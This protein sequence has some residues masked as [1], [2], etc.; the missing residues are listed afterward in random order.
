MQA[1]Y[2]KLAMTLMQ[3]LQEQNSETKCSL[4]EKPWHFR[5][6]AKKEYSIATINYVAPEVPQPVHLLAR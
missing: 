1:K 6:R 2:A 5:V 4:A 3:I